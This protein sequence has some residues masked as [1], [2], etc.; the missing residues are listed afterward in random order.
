MFRP[1]LK[2]YKYSLP[3]NTNVY[4]V[5][6]FSSLLQLKLDAVIFFNLVLQ[7]TYMYKCFLTGFIMFNEAKTFAFIEELYSSC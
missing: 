2:H 3:Y 4:S 1:I 6:P 7:A 5:H